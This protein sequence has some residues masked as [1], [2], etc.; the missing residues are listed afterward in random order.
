[1]LEP[2]KLNAVTDKDLRSI[3][4]QF[5]LR[6]SFET[7]TLSCACCDT[8]LGWNNLGAVVVNG[9]KLELFCEKPECITAAGER[10]SEIASESH[11]LA[12]VG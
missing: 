9:S 5:D 2:I 1:V 6:Q 11:S 8:I 12:S 3:L 7:G 4:E 10:G